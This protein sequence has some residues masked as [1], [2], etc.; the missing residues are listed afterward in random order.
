MNMYQLA[1]YFGPMI[2]SHASLKSMLSE[3][4][5]PNDKIYRLLAD[6]Q[7]LSLKKGLYIFSPDL[8]KNTPSAIIVANQ[9][10]G[11]S[12]V[13]LEYA[14]SYYQAIPERV[15]VVTSVTTKATKAINTP[16]GRF[17]YSHI[18]KSYYNIGLKQIAC[19]N[20]FFG[21]IACPEKALIDTIVMTKGL[22]FRS[23]KDVSN[24]LIEDMRIDEDW[25][26]KLNLQLVTE[27]QQYAQK[28]NSIQLL[29]KYL[30][31]I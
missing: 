17:T 27:I 31:S 22:I 13:S 11:P 6:K 21:I 12:Y 10:I 8:A 14:L 16:I 26:R 3:Y 29:I 18:S 9:L 15:Y 19:E 20:G 7:L 2:V 28:K 30:Q 23:L 5:N 4:T 25:L 24:Y 1:N